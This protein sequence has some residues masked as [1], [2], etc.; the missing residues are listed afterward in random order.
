MFQMNIKRIAL[1]S[2]FC[3][4]SFH[5]VAGKSAQPSLQGSM[6]IVTSGLTSTSGLTPTPAAPLSRQ[7]SPLGQNPTVSIDFD[8]DVYS[9]PS[10]NS[11][12]SY[13]TIV[14]ENEN[15]TSEEFKGTNI[16]VSTSST[17]PAGDPMPLAK[18]TAFEK[19]KAKYSDYKTR[20]PGTN[21]E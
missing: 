7:I 16:A 1:A 3:T 18:A 9:G 11:N 12:T 6:S 21:W 20:F 14:I 8:T 5:V 10:T 13:Y 19:L 2:L 15:G 4:M 17:K